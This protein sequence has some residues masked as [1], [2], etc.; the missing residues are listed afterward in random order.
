MKKCPFCAEEIQDEAIKC[1]F[2]GESLD[3][4]LKSKTKWYFTTSA[5]VVALLCL[6]PLALPLVWLNPRYKI[7]TKLVVT[8][9]V[10]ALTIVF[11][12][13]SGYIYHNLMEQIE[14]LGVR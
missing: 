2:C 1:R 11:C 12:Y 7:I 14:A 4:S 6:G 9:I 10:I 13:L 5:V 3:N 8:F